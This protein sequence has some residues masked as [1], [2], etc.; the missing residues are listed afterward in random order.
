MAKSPTP[1]KH[2]PIKTRE[3]PL[4]KTKPSKAVPAVGLAKKYQAPAKGK[5]GKSGTKPAMPM[6]KPMMPSKKGC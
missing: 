4:P 6:K 1:A 3:K 5:P 2:K